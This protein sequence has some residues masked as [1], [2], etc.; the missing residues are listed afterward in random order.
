LRAREA[1]T[2]GDLDHASFKRIEDDAIRGVIASQKAAGC[3]VAPM[4]SSDANHSRAS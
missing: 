3:Q 1:H 2:A 4:A